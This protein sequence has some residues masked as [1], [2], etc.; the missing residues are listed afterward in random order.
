MFAISSHLKK[1][2]W[3]VLLA[4][5]EV[6]APAQTPV[7]KV[8]T[9][10]VQVRSLTVAE[11]AK[12]I[13][14]EL[15]GIVLADAVTGRALVL[16][17]G[18]EAIYAVGPSAQVSKYRRGDV[19]EISGVTDPGGFAPIVT[20]RTCK[21]V[22][23]APVPEPQRLTYDELTRKQ[24]D[25]QY[26]EITGVVRSTEPTSDPNDARTRMV[27]ETGGERLAIRLHARLATNTLV[28]SEVRVRGICFCRYNVAR[29][30]IAPVLDIPRGVEVRVEK[31]APEKPW[32][33]PLIAAA[34]LMKFAPDQD[35][36]HRVRVHGIVTSQQPGGTLW[37][38]DGNRGL[39]VLSEPDFRLLPGDEV[40]VLGFP[41]QGVYS[42]I[43]EDAIF[44]KIS[45]VAPPSPVVVTN[46]AAAVHQDAGLIELEAKLTARR[47]VQDGWVLTLDW[48]TNIVEVKINLTNGMTLPPEWQSGSQVRV[49]GICSVAAPADGIALSGVWEPNSFSLAMRSLDDLTVIKPAPWWTPAH[50]IL[51]LVAAFGG[52]LLVTGV[53][54]L[55]ARR[56][57]N[58]QERQR[59]MAEA[60]FTAIL[61][62]RNRV[63]REIHDTLAQGLVATSV[64]L[65]LA[66]KTAMGS[67]ES[68]AHHLDAAQQLVS[69]SLEEARNSIWNMRA[70][71]LE[72]GD[73]ASALRGILKQMAEGSDMKTAF[74][75]TG[76]SCRLA[77]VI[78]SN[79]LRVGQEAITNAARHAQA[80]KLVVRMEFDRKSFRLVVIDDG[81]GFNP[82]APPPSDGGFGLVGIRERAAE[83]K[84][85]LII[86]S[87][88]GTGTEIRF[89]VP[90]G[91]D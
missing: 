6:M 76:Q 33:M 18:A 79:L 29:Q 48:Q 2:I 17:D 37:L 75:I 88:P 60:E 16:Q 23:T 69:G 47:P 10:A 51:V 53:L 70:Q 13:P 44:R 78:E 34:E 68:L 62:E 81:R 61:S 89:T 43:V 66:R 50:V 82:A 58:E 74:E 54:A 40:E 22:G 87:Q 24:Y 39:R 8:L 52:L 80:G 55:L 26:V 27:I 21:K 64:Q 83:L 12:A 36:G 77:P 59:A 35:Y 5:L 41:R 38:R 49:A 90:L 20:I 11:A 32:D 84:G 72:T 91:G 19:L 42:P 73:L 7:A 65:R 3:I 25:S 56:R 9:N 4:G 31:P 1:A 14:V 71:V 86:R 30:F 46:L 67:P 45:R 15:R 57:L 28:D 63:A 85:E